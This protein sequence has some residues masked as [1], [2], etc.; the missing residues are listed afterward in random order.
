MCVY[1]DI[2][3]ISLKVSLET[4]MTD[5]KPQSMVHGCMVAGLY[6]AWVHLSIQM[7]ASIQKD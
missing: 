3:R 5:S 1:C 7:Q 6:G 2:L 4:F